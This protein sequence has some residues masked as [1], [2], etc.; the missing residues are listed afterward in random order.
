MRGC[1]FAFPSGYVI[2]L[3]LSLSPQSSLQVV[4]ILLHFQFS[5]LLWQFGCLKQLVAF[6]NQILFNSY[7]DG[8]SKWMRGRIDGQTI[9]R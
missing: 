5:L 9:G 3:S 7:A 6:R 4:W 2:N 1:S 8:E